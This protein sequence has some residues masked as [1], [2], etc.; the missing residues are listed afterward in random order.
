MQWA[1]SLLSGSKHCL[2]LGSARPLC[3]DT[4]LMGEVQWEQ[5]ICTYKGCNIGLMIR[6][7]AYNIP[8]KV[9]MERCLEERHCV[10]A[11]VLAEVLDQAL[12]DKGSQTDQSQVFSTGPATRPSAAYSRLPEPAYT[13][14]PTETG[15]HETSF[16][17]PEVPAGELPCPPPKADGASESL[18]RRAHDAGKHA[19]MKLSEPRLRV[20]ET[21]QL[22]GSEHR[23]N[24]WIVVLRGKE[25]EGHSFGVYHSGRT[26]PEC[27]FCHSQ[28]RA[29]RWQSRVLCS[30]TRQPFPDSVFH[31]FASNAEVE[32]YLAGAGFHNSDIPWLC[33]SKADR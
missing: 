22:R 5:K 26:L 24:S 30:R 28:K 6:G 9:A 32:A 21:P 4:C 10:L 15:P 16:L 25:F 29:L 1:H 17:A 23:Q 19:R 31:G 14:S 33:K 12:A 18:L 11:K 20:P 8:G 7:S 2:L 3:G 27:D 13:Q